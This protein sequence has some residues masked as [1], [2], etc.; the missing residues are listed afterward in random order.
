MIDKITAG[1]RWTV[2]SV[3]NL[4]FTLFVLCAVVFMTAIT[5]KLV[6]ES[7]IMPGTPDGIKF[8]DGGHMYDSVVQDPRLHIVD[9]IGGTSGFLLIALAVICIFMV[10]DTTES[11]EDDSA[12]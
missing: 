8:D 7:T 2:S 12:E 6:L 11:A 4:F 5:C 3:R 1:I 10:A 9:I